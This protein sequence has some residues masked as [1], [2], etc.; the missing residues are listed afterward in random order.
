MEVMKPSEAE[1]VHM[2]TCSSHQSVA[3]SLACFGSSLRALC[4]VAAALLHVDVVVVNHIPVQ[5]VQV[6]GSHG[7]ACLFAARAG[8]LHG[9]C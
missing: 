6:D 8:M 9:I 4:A 7:G 5:T 3:P 2:L 1:C